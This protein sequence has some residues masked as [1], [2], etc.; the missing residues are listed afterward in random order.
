MIQSKP[1]LDSE[2][3]IQDMA[4]DMD[5]QVSEVSTALNQG[6]NK[7]FFTFINEFRVNEAKSRILDNKNKHLTLL[8]IGYDSGFNSK[9]SFNAL[10]K[11]HTG[12]TPSQFKKQAEK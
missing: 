3:T 4:D 11:K 7:N 8:A 2:L 1:Y 6:M 12:V 9:S 10:F 5:I